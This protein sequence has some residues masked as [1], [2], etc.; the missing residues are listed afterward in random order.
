M[1]GI[2]RLI[3]SAALAG[4]TAIGAC[5]GSAYYDTDSGYYATVPP[6][7]PVYEYPGYA[8]YADG[9][10]ING[11]WGWGG[12]NYVWNRGYWTH[13]RPGF[14]WVPHRWARSGNGWRF[15]TGGWRRRAYR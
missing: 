11:Y 12:N 7:A 14:T 13:N 8:P 10:W 5:A 4:L 6:P 15:Y 3:A 1:K 2:K 9:I